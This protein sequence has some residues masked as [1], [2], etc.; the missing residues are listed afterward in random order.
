MKLKILTGLAIALLG[1]LVFS[2]SDDNGEEDTKTYTLSVT[3][4]EG[5]VAVADKSTYRKGEE[6]TV[7]AT[8]D[9]DY[10]FIGWFENEERVY[11][12]NIYTFPMPARDLVLTAKFIMKEPVA[13]EVEAVDLGL[14]IK[15]AAW[16]VGA[17]APEQFG[18]LYGWADPTGN[19]HSTDL[20]DYPSA[21]PPADIC[22]SE[23]DIA[24]MQWGNG[25]RMPSQAEFQE[26][27]D[28]C[29]W[30]WTE[31]NGVAGRRA[32]A[33]NGNS[34][35][36]PAAASRDGENISNQVGQRGCY[37]SGTLYPDNDSRYA[38]YFYFYDNNQFAN[39]NNR[40]YM[41]YSVRPVKN[42]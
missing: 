1:G 36:F 3:A 10:L 17:E 11:D 26:L 16:N 9:K 41:G 15:W 33:A 2:C 42:N 34:I 37:W 7:R 18:G 29:T 4:D 19:N 31:V 30:E 21:T 13:N 39:R 27:V 20:D 38:Y 14:S 6:V 23:Y 12:E 24:H 22:G 25:W 40:R 28:N 35:F 8:E 5:G 32:T